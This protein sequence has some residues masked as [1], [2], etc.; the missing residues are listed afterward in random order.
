MSN[1]L[2]VN[3]AA[4]QGPE[5]LDKVD[6]RE[7]DWL[8]RTFG[9]WFKLT[10]PPGPEKGASFVKREANRRARL[11]SVIGLFYFTFLLL[12]LVPSFFSTRAALYANL[13]SYG[14]IICALVANRLGKVKTGS[15]ILVLL[16]ES[17]LVLSITAANPLDVAD[18]PLYDIFIIG[19]LIAVSLLPIQ[20]VFIF[21]IL[22]SAF[23]IGDLLYQPHSLALAMVLQKQLIVVIARP[24][25][26]QLIVAAVLS[27]WV[28][29]TMKANE[30][31]NRAEMVATVEHALAEQHA[32]AEKE[33][34]ELET[35]IQQLVQAHVDATNGQI[36]ARIPY[37][38]SK[39]LWPL[40]GVFNS[41][42]TRLQHSQYNERALQQL[43]EAISSYSAT[44][45]QAAEVPQSPL[46]LQRSGT[47]LDALIL[48]VKKLHESSLKIGIS[49][50]KRDSREG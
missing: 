22:N 36:N 17:G 16:I 34:Q 21:A 11:L 50:R 6:R 18:T 48:S 38:S 5:F 41:L 29:S 15:I 44:L 9:W 30:R 46:V 26:I 47:D 31:A 4:T 13:F 33:K 27:L 2:P 25:C 8:G 37:P 42:W 40:V 1:F 20:G 10:M 3:E 14:M 12:V 28:N 23:I 32:I 24:V 43:K 35:S 39:V 45:H 49:Q 19:E 7:T